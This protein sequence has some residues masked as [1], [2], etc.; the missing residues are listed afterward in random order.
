MTRFKDIF[1]NQN[2]TMEQCA[3]VVSAYIYERK[4]VDVKINTSYFITPHHHAREDMLLY[5]AY[6]IAKD[7][8]NSSER[9]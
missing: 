1:D 3:E 8:F 7:F 9:E 4:G 2:P 6:I 5:R